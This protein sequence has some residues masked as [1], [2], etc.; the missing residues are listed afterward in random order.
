ME[1]L[2]IEEIDGGRVGGS[3]LEAAML[4]AG[5]RISPKGIALEPGHA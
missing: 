1:R 4:A 5:G 2:R 3:G